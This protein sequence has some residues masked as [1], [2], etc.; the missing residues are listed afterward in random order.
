MYSIKENQNSKN[1]S[2][3]ILEYANEEMVPCSRQ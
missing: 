2:M 1:Q 3:E